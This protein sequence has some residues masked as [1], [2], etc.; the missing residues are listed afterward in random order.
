M[1]VTAILACHN[2]RDQTIECLDSYF[3][4]AIGS[5]FSLA[6]VL[7]DDGSIDGTAQ[8]VRERHPEAE[9][10]Q[11][12][13]RLFWAGGMALAEQAARV[14]DPDYF[15]WLNDDV[16]LDSDGLSRLI[17]TAGRNAEGC[18]AVGALRDPMTGELTYSGVRRRG[19]HPL[20]VDR[21]PPGDQPIA[22]DTFN[23]NAVLVPRRVATAVG[24]IDAGFVHGIADFDYGLRAAKA[25]I[26]NLL[27]Q[28]T[29]GT[30]PANRS[31]APW[32]DR[33]LS[34]GE[35]VRAL[36]GPKSGS[37]RA[38][39]RFLRRHG[40]PAWPLF[41]LAPYMRAAPSLV[42]ARHREGPTR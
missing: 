13:G 18:I 12:D 29:V 11:G 1:R 21:V 38:R 40:G 22:V 15:L 10:I 27:T 14:H 41:W 26:A 19:L 3:A 35:R 36:V 34:R 33:S 42:R 9:V 20:R 32:T 5:S 25:G 4:Q 6:A 17:K 23:G 16:V 7:V 24:L 30:C 31:E 39:A 8:A 28:G 37:P 2:R